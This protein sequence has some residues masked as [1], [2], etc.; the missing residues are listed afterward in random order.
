[1]ALY[2]VSVRDMAEIARLKLDCRCR[3]SYIWKESVSALLFKN[4]C[5]I[6]AFQMSSL[7][8]IDASL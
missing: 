7:V 5:E 8:F 6:C 3:M 1:M 2:S 4:D